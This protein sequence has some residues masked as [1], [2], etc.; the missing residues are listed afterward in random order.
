ML[1]VREQQPATTLCFVLLTLL[2]HP[3]MIDF[4]MIDFKRIDFKITDFNMI[5]FKSRCSASG[6]PTSR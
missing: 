5:D 2:G 1:A 6:W 4:K 3:L